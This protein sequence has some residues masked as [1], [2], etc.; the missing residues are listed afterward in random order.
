MDY[1]FFKKP[2][3]IEVSAPPKGW[4]TPGATSSPI[5]KVPPKSSLDDLDTA[6]SI[7]DLT[8]LIEDDDDVT[9]ATHKTDSSK[10]K[11]TH[12]SSKWQGSPPVKKA[13]PE[14][15]ASQKTSKSKSHKMSCTSWDE[16]EECEESRKEPE[17]KEMCYLTFALVTGLEWSIFK[18]CSFDQPPMS[19]PSPLQ[20]SDKPSPGSKS[21]YSN[22]TRW[23]Q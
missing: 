6:E 12:R 23:L 7:V 16:R 11:E 21:T 19:H 2:L 8:V 9:F 22:S 20:G 1:A 3:P 10:S 17:Y 14:G 5:S 4:G 15:P 18:K 13:S